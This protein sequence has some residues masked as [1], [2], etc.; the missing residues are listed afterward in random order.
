[1]ED[2]DNVITV[3]HPPENETLCGDER[4]I[5]ECRAD[6]ASVLEFNFLIFIEKRNTC[7]LLMANTMLDRVSGTRFSRYNESVATAMDND[8]YYCIG[9]PE[10][11]LTRI[12]SKDSYTLNKC[13]NQSTT[14]VPRT[15][16]VT[17]FSTSF[18]STTSL[19]TTQSITTSSTHDD[20]NTTTSKYN[21]ITIINCT[22]NL[23]VLNK[24]S[25]TPT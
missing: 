20:M 17:T 2:T 21:V 8:T 19:E 25:L 6:P 16:T 23:H 12:R 11:R 1:M 14:E 22:N 7:C 24:T 3:I 18:I 9:I 13:I 10:Q 5:I 4:L 15:T